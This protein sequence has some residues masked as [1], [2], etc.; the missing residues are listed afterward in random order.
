[1]TEPHT[2][3]PSSLVTFLDCP[4]RWA[5]QHLTEMVTDYGFRLN[6]TRPT[7]VGACVGSGVH[8]GA[9]YTLNEKR[10]TGGLG[11]A[12]EAEDRAVGELKARMEWGVSWDGTTAN[13]NTAQR[14][15]AR[16]TLAYRTHLAPIIEPL[17]IEERLDADIGE[18]W[19]LSGQPDTMA[20]DPQRDIRD[21][22]TGVRRRANSVQ[23]G[24]YY[25]LLNAHHYQP[26]TIM[27]DFL[28]RV[29]VE[30]EQ[31]PP[32]TKSMP[33]ALAVA[34]ALE[35]IDDI[36]RSTRRFEGRLK[37]DATGR[38]PQT[39]FRANPNS[40]LCGEKW[41]RA[42]GTDFCHAHQKET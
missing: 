37:G 17:V 24:A 33:I 31:P 40:Q 16:M 26:V 36:M 34:D 1:M 30:K 9:G 11:S 19:I 28:P 6:Q 32:I 8:A 18:G 2:I 14:Q 5:A 15:V 42:W 22:K 12:T 29:R 23:Y 20:G 7:H 13:L 27:E 41:C 38:A 39:A 21:L 25:V 3:R 4:R 10:S 35:A